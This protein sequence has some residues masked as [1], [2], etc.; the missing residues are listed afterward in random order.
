MTRARRVYTQRAQTQA[1]RR[2]SKTKT[3]ATTK[4]R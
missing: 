3:K 1:L 4:P 2:P